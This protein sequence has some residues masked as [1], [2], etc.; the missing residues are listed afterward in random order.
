MA[1]D[2]ERD[3]PFTSLETAQVNALL[4]ELKEADP[5]P[6]GLVPD[7]M[8]QIRSIQSRG[9]MPRQ[10]DARMAKKVMIGL[11]A[12][13]AML[14]AVFAMTGWPPVDLGTQGTV[15][16]AKRYQAQQMSAADVKLGDCLGAAVPAERRR[17]P[18]D[19]GSAGAVAPERRRASE[20]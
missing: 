2:D 3:E 15:G 10:G 17:G 14:I 8:A 9:S 6:P 18:A 4:D 13:A 1:R 20:P 12:A 16:A 11:A 5:P 19:E 7:V